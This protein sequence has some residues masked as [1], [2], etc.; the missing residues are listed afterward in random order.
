MTAPSIGYAVLDEL[1][2][3][4]ARV[5][6]VEGHV[7]VAPAE[8]PIPDALIVWARAHREEV[9]AVMRTE[10]ATGGSAPDSRTGAVR[11][12]PKRRVRGLVSP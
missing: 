7:K 5:Y 8:A 12:S 6:L 11:N 3:R 2:G 1:R 10:A 4:G 9:L